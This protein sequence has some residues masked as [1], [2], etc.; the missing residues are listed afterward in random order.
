[1]VVTLLECL[2][3]PSF[4]ALFLSSCLSNSVNEGSSV[5]LC[6]RT[7]PNAFEAGMRAQLSQPIPGKSRRIQWVAVKRIFRYLQQSKKDGFIL[8]GLSTKMELVNYSDSDFA[9]LLVIVSQLLDM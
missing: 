3:E 7:I 9:V 4:H 5:I 1:M 2:N 8:G 6:W